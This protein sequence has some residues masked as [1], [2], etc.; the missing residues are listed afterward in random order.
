MV[1]STQRLDKVYI[2]KNNQLLEST[3]DKALFDIVSEIKQRGPENT[4][5][6]S[7]KFTDLETLFASKIF[8][9]SIGSKLFDCRFDNAQFI[10]DA[11]ASYVLN[12]SI[13]EIENADAI[14]LIGSNPRWEA[15]V[16]NARIR[17]AY[18]QN[19]CKIGLIG[20]NINLNY[21]F[22]H[23]SNS[24]AHIN[25]IQDGT[26]SFCKILKEAKNPLIII[27]TSAINHE[28]GAKSFK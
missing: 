6:I 13:Q 11:R 27:G 24:I 2:K 7:G 1:L 25:E 10:E 19:D 14:L 22:V 21:N 8:L 23:L 4:I 12:S 26:S 9:E 18:L 17:K 3:W 15:S 20:K 28:E 16:L 5:S